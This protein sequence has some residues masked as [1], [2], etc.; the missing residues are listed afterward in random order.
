MGRV[1]RGG[2]EGDAHGAGRAAGV[3]ARDPRGGGTG[4]SWMRRNPLSSRLVSKGNEAN[5]YDNTAC[6]RKPQGYLQM[7]VLSRPA[8]C[9]RL[10]PL[11]CLSTSTQHTA[12][13]LAVPGRLG[14]LR[15]QCWCPAIHQKLLTTH[16]CRA[17]RGQQAAGPGGRRGGEEERGG[18]VAGAAGQPGR[19]GV[20]GEPH[21]HGLRAQRA[22]AVPQQWQGDL[23]QPANEWH[24]ATA[25]SPAACV[26]LSKA[27]PPRSTQMQLPA[28]PAD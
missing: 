8:S 3:P 21:R 19:R 12:P 10:Q 7:T 25:K 18:R 1:L 15:H 6:S 14:D 23:G 27:G 9:I 13:G 2:D 26:L 5:N 24:Y 16:H 28:G 17:E 11:V 4:A 22:Q 20:E